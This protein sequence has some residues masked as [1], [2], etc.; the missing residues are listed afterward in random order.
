MGNVS[1]LLGVQWYSGLP[2]ANPENTTGIA[3]IA[4][5]AEKIVG[6]NLIGLQLG[7]G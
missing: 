3:E 5:I 1:A 2:F 6:S 7:R 4:E